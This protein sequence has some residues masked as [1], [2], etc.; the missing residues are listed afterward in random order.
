MRHGDDPARPAWR[1]RL[2]DPTGGIAALL[3]RWIADVTVADKEQA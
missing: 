1:E 3:N 2:R